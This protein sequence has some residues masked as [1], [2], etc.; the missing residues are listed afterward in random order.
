MKH[1]VRAATLDVTFFEKMCKSRQ[2]EEQET[3]GTRVGCG[4][5]DTGDQRS[6]DEEERDTTEHELHRTEQ[7]LGESLA[8]ERVLWTR[9]ACK[10]GTQMYKKPHFS[11]LTYPQATLNADGAEDEVKRGQ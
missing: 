2:R 11:W 6:R 8:R 9:P 3:E 7:R 1:L 5:E 4:G 10:T